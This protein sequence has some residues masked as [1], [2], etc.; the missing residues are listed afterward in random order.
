MEKQ[1]EQRSAADI[2]GPW[3]DPNFE[4]GLIQRCRSHWG[5]PIC[6]LP[7]VIVATFL[8]QELALTFVIREARRRIEAGLCD[9][10]ELYDG[11]HAEALAHAEKFANEVD[12]P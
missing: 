3:Q 6:Q 4:A 12:N 11:Q 5:V 7:D 8:R 2:V 1:P 9:D 10:T